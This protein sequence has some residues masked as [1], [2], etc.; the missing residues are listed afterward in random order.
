MLTIVFP[1]LWSKL[2]CLS[3]MRYYL[4]IATV[5]CY[6]CWGTNWKQTE[7]GRC[8]IWK[9]VLT[10]MPLHIISEVINT[11]RRYNATTI[12][13]VLKILTLSLRGNHTVL[14][15]NV[16]QFGDEELFVLTLLYIR[17]K[18]TYIKININILYMSCMFCH[19]FLQT[20]WSPCFS[21]STTRR[22]K[23]SLLYWFLHNLVQTLMSP[24]DEL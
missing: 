20:W 4:T 19:R 2:R 7:T 16:L 18:H 9:T 1:Q 11:M 5:C 3:L 6:C 24:E 23:F 12:S 21:S 8:F 10:Q 22:L 13:I 17:E 15:T 14:F